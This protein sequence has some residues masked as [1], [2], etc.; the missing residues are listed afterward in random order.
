MFLA[1]VASC[2]TLQSPQSGNEVLAPD[3]LLTTRVQGLQAT[4][5]TAN[6][7]D[8]SG[9]NFVTALQVIVRKDS[10]Q[11]NATQLSIPLSA[12]VEAGDAVLASFWLRS[13]QGPGRIE[14]LFEKSQSPWTKSAILVA[15]ADQTWHRFQVP[16]TA[17]ESYSPGDAMASFRFAFGPQTVELGGIDVT[18]FGKAQSLDSLGDAVAA[19]SPL[20]TVTVRFDTKHSLQTM[21]GLGGDFCQARYGS[22][23]VMDDVGHYVLNHLHVAHA[24][25]GLPLNYWEPKR[26]EDHVDAQGGA[27]PATASFL[28]MFLLKERRIPIVLSIWEGP[29]WLVGSNPQEL[30]RSLQPSQ[31]R[32]CIDAV[33]R[34]LVLARDKYGVQ[35]DDL[36]FNEPDSGVNFMFTPQTMGDFIRQAGPVLKSLGLKTKFL[37]G[38]TGGGSSLAPFANT[39]LED[40]SLRDYLGPIAFHSW[41]AMNVKD[42][43][44]EGIRALGAKFGKPIW[45]LECGYDAGLWRQEGNPFATWDNALKLAL[46]YEKTIRLSG[47]SVMDYWTYQDN[48]PLVDKNGPK[49]YPAFEVVR[50]MEEVF[51]SGQKVVK[52][53]S[54]TSELRALGTIDSRGVLYVL[55]VNPGGLGKAK[56][57][58]FKPNATVRIETRNLAGGKISYAKASVSGTLTVALPTRSALTIV[59]AVR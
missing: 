18:D 56:V 50:Q 19:N 1:L 30:G 29:E 25:V 54:N 58:G 33:A 2:L 51:G 23:E 24:R 48:Y 7:I 55:L 27:S 4:N 17:A 5:A 16:F 45:C 15:A 11:T 46:A 36:S 21:V 52:A 14:F 40:P 32:A 31:Y 12:Q 6:L 3:A 10:T 41:D 28:T 26:G 49:P 39:L 47:A 42:A 9:H 20:G 57:S 43:D 44:Y 53:A 35:V 59:P 22:T 8:A 37:V 13:K 34:Y 38:D